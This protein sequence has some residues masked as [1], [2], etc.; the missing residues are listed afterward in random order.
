MPL[1]PL[2]RRLLVLLDDGSIPAAKFSSAMRARLASLFQLAVLSEEKSGGGRRIVVKND[3]ALR[4]WI[5]ANYPSGLVGIAAELPPR[6]ESVANFADSKR[7]RPIDVWLV[8]LRG[9]GDAV[10]RRSV[11]AMPLAEL[12][13]GFGV[14]AAILEPRDP[15]QID[16]TLALVENL[17]LFLHVERVAPDVDVALWYAG[18]VPGRVLDWVAAL[19]ARQF[20]HMPDYDPVGLDEYLKVRARV[21]DRAR[22]FVPAD[23]EGRVARFGRAQLLEDS[24]AVLLRV[25]KEADSAVRAV[26]DVL[27]R[28]GKG[29]EQEALL[30]AGDER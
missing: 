2:A 7:G 25:R 28:H 10:L 3:T 8:F 11:G 30:I 17:E 12:T 5:A 29:L 23:L 9:F 15:W 6:A 16:G 26:L 14:T 24:E 21:G 27:D 19:P 22:L 18:R 20:L 1:D 13:R 4:Q